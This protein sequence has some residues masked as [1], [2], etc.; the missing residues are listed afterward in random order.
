MRSTFKILFYLNTSKKKQ[1]GLCPV[2]GRITVDGGIAQFSIK[3]YAHP[4]SWDVNNGTEFYEHKWIAK[5]LNTNYF[6]A[7]PYASWER[8]LNEF[9]NGLIRQY[10]PKKVNFINYSDTDIENFQKKIN[11]RPRKLLNFENPKNKFFSFYK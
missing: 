3:E 7:H 11:R 9:T 10:I 1:S 2:L 6:F 8:G 4:D 5:K